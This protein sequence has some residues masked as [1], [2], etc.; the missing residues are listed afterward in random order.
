ML[1]S[2]ITIVEVLWILF[3]AL[4]KKV[5]IAEV[6]LCILFFE[7][8]AHLRVKDSSSLN[9]FVAGLSC[10]FVFSICYYVFV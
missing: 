1:L 8:V 6:C 7:F 9:Y 10:M 2:F 3:C 5:D 4:Y